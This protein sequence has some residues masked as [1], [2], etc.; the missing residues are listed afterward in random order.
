MGRKSTSH[1]PGA[2]G[3]GRFQKAIP[4][5]TKPSG[6]PGPPR[7][8]IYSEIGE[9]G[10][11]ISAG[12]VYE[13]RVKTLLQEK[14][15]LVFYEMSENDATIG[16]LI[17]MIENL[18]RSMDWEFQ[19]K[20]MDEEVADEEQEQSIEFC[21]GMFFEDMETS[22]DDFISDVL[23]MLVFGWSWF[24]IVFKR[25]GGMNKF[26]PKSHSNFD[27]GKIGIRKLAHRSQISLWQW[28]F[29]QNGDVL[30]M[31]Q[32]APYGTGTHIIPRNKSVH[33]KT[34][35]AKGNPEGKSLLRNAWLP[36]YYL[37][38]VQRQEAI[39]MERDLNGLPVI[40]L[41]M[42]L[43]NSDDS[44]DVTAVNEYIKMGR[45]I[46]MNEQSSA[47]IPSDPF[48][49]SM[50]EP[51]SVRQVEFE[52]LSSNNSRS[53]DTTLVKRSYKE[54]ICRSV[55][56]QFLMMTNV[57]S[58]GRSESEM[59]LFI[60]SLLSLAEN[61]GETFTRDVITPIWMLNKMNPSTKPV[62]VPGKLRKEKITELGEFVERMMKSGV[63]TYDP[64]LEAFMRKKS[65]LPESDAQYQ[66]EQQVIEE[67][68]RQMEMD[69]QRLE[70]E[71]MDAQNKNAQ[72]Q[73]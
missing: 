19:T 21:R 42:E 54:D 40:R 2:N 6:I 29:A 17:Y 4:P 53:I 43:L 13:E 24:E 1:I 9:F 70:L 10:I 45:D 57:G 15:R 8:G 5:D 47:I 26:D 48:Y 58:Y 20:E 59:D 66:E 3:N 64:M 55:L 73:S 52:L 30:A 34:K 67:E 49:N 11:N 23:T 18:L 50:G 28:Q 60:M 31:V 61:I 7:T 27:D 63:F 33:F 71:G 14:G 44:E 25:R 65:G 39:S 62:L 68:Q 32:Q 36:W 22:W 16:G 35:N 72:T 51:T 41:P 12:R 37:N 38:H 69:R 56:A 46:K